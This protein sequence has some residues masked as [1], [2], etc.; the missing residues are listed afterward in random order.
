V[1]FCQAC[2]RNYREVTGLDLDRLRSAS[3]LEASVA[4]HE[5]ARKCTREDLLA[6]R[7]IIHGSGKFMLCHNGGTW[8][9]W[10]LP[11]QYRVP[12]GFM[13]EHSDQIYERLMHG[14][15]GASMARPY[16]KLSQM[17][18][19][20][21]SLASDALPKHNAPH[22]KHNATLEDA[23]EVRMEG[24]ANLAA[25]GVPIYAT[26][27]RL[28]YRIGSGSA[29]P[30]RETF[31]LM[32]RAEPII[33]DSEPV[34]YVS[35]V[36]TWESL[37][38][39]RAG[40]TTW[41]WE[42]STGFLLAMLDSHISVDVCPNTE[43]SEERLNRQHVI[44]LCGASGI[45]DEQV[46]MLAGWVWRGGGLLATYD[47]GLYDEKGQLRKDGGA[48]KQILGAEIRG[49]PLRA[50]PEC[51]YRIQTSHPALG[52]YEKGSIVE[53][54]NQL[55]PVVVRDGAKVLADCW[56]LGTGESRGPAV[57]ANQ[58]GKG[59]AIYVNGSLENF[60]A[61]ERVASIQRMLASM[62]RYLGGNAPL[63]FELSAPAGVYG[64]LRRATNGDVA[65]WV[66]APVGF[67]D[68]AAGRMR[69]QFLPVENVEIRILVPEQRQI[70]A[71]R[72]LR[73]DRTVPFNL[74][75]PYAVVTIPLLH[76]A[77]LVHVA[78]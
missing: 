6:F 24:F 47:T 39:W 43:M 57:I 78:L 40:Q 13:L 37:Q 69:Q 54:D 7:E 45:S 60:Y 19:G 56:N 23:D 48:L 29:E 4:W 52:Q 30:A 15:M 36:P 21:H 5:W 9:G 59:R 42:M 28:Y 16:K 22:S 75:G 20:S 18:L 11:L 31:D 65:L 73:A 76:I 17:Y 35:I 71:V 53:G 38:R 10:S 67:K 49:G 2:R 41:N 32:R 77:E 27:N 12:D 51:Y 3:D 50:M 34:P 55:L 70:K 44:A 63:P 8:Q 14:M 1:C 26:A 46:A 61:C 33:K 25:G 72:L 74:S 66:L 58:Y 62:V 64:L 68:A